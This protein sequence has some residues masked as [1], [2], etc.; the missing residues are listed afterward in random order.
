MI[1]RVNLQEEV[2]RCELRQGKMAWQMC[3][4]E[5]QKTKWNAISSNSIWRELQPNS[6]QEKEREKKPVLLDPP[7][8]LALF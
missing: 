7:T 2:E 1:F 5:M 8:S 3:A 6:A 4:C